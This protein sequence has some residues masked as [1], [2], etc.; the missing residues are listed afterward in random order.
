MTYTAFMAAKTRTV[1]LCLAVLCLPAL[2]NVPRA[3]LLSEKPH[4]GVAGFVLASHRGAAA[5]NPLIAMG[6]AGYLCDEGRR[7]R[8]TGKERDA[9]TGLDYF[10]IRYLSGAQGRF[11]SAD[12]MDGWQGDPQSWNKYAY[13]RNNPLLYT[14]PSGMRYTICDTSGNCHDDYSD[15]DFDKNLSGTSKNGVIYDN[16]G[17]KIGTY[18]RT[19]FDDLSPMG[20]MFFNEMSNRRAESNGKIAIFGAASGAT[21][22]AGG[23][24]TATGT[25]AAVI[26]GVT[27]TAEQLA[28][29]GP[30]VL[31]RLVAAGKLSIEAIQRL[32]AQVP[33]VANQVY[34]RLFAQSNNTTIPQG[35]LNGNNYFRIGEGFAPGGP[36]FRIAIGS[37]HVPLPSWVPGLYK[38]TLHINLWRR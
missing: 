11:T 36:V 9:E 27:Y 31:A 30:V 34:L 32:A 10:D 13:A 5:D 1:L 23:V 37:K 4:Q 33:Q 35:W 20:N 7:S 16:D 14:D 21:G 15:A 12:P 22:V 2:A 29:L 17:N 6:I 3:S 28:A 19:S 18:Q 24:A 38:G 8:S 26:D 25:V